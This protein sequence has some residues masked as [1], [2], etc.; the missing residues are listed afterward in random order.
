[1]YLPYLYLWDN[2]AI[3]RM[4][5]QCV[6]RC[7]H[8]HELAFVRAADSWL[9][10]WLCFFAV[11]LGYYWV[12][13]R[14]SCIPLALRPLR[15]PTTILFSNFCVSQFHR[16]GHEMNIFWAIHSVRQA[17]LQVG[18]CLRF[19]VELTRTRCLSTVLLRV[20]LLRAN[21]CAHTL[22]FLPSRGLRHACRCLARRAVRA[23]GRVQRALALQPHLPVLVGSSLGLLCLR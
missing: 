20:A 12:T 19:C 21:R 9:T 18:V 3:H 4:P 15:K 7:C 5:G 1:M 6:F 22:S 23:A 17:A 8:L 10:W 2:Y 11:D 14:C 13:R 16:L